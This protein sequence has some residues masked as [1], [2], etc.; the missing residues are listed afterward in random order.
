MSYIYSIIT[1]KFVYISIITTRIGAIYRISY[2]INGKECKTLSGE[3]RCV[4]EIIYL[5]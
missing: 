5:K 2:I 3:W 4:R 1:T